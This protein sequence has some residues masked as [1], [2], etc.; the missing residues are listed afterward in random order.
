MI[1]CDEI[2]RTSDLPNGVRPGDNRIRQLAEITLDLRL[3]PS[4]TPGTCV[5]RHHPALL[6][7]NPVQN[8][9]CH[10]HRTTMCPT[11]AAA[12]PPA[13]K[14]VPSGDTSGEGDTAGA[15]GRGG[16]TTD[17]PALEGSPVSSREDP[18]PDTDKADENGD[19]GE[20]GGPTDHLE[21][22]AHDSPPGTPDNTLNLP[23]VRTVVSTDSAGMYALG[24]MVC[25]FLTEQEA[26]RL[27]DQKALPLPDADLQGNVQAPSRH[28][29][30]MDPSS[31][32]RTRLV[33]V[34]SLQDHQRQ[35]FQTR[36]G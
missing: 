33:G 15:G 32:G 1:D 19:E 6:G 13:A 21:G 29:F 24:A 27:E 30:S 31:L 11:Y 8:A 18:S 3:F 2:T 17:P 25:S 20:G 26:K 5:N 12:R 28:D 16:Q 9:I 34:P 22:V 4:P 10:L 7:S 23:K 36:D 14:R 35:G